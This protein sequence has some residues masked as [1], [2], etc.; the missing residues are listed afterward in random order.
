MTALTASLFAAANP[1]TQDEKFAVI[2][3]A[4]RTLTAQGISAHAAFDAVLG[5]G[6]WDGLVADLYASLRGEA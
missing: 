6:Q 4:I 2:S 1:Q 5:A 3:F